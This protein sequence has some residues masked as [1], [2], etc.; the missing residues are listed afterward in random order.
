M[1]SFD[2][3][4]NDSPKAAVSSPKQKKE[5]LAWANDHLDVLQEQ[6]TNKV[7]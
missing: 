1:M 6:E 3:N 4:K 2:Q 5:S 7:I